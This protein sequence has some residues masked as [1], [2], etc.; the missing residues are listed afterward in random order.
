[1]CSS[2][3]FEAGTVFKFGSPRLL[4]DRSRSEDSAF[5]F[6]ISPAPPGSA[7]IIDRQVIKILKFLF[8]LEK[9][10]YAKYTVSS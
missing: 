10:Y 9:K 2:A 1:M 4:P 6:D 3:G 8:G 7:D 5:D